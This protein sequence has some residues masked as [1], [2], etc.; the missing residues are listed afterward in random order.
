MKEPYGEGVAS[1]SGPESCGCNRKGTL[2]ALTGVRTG[3]VLSLESFTPRAPTTSYSAEGDTGRT[4]SARYAPGPA[5]SETPGTYGNSLHGIREIPCLAREDGQSEGR[6]GTES[7]WSRVPRDGKSD[8]GDPRGTKRNL[9][10][11]G[12]R[13][14]PKGASQ[15]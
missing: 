2:E 12:P 11:P 13:W 14:E 6:R 4:V 10:D 1:H 9:P 3:W 8:E 5:G 7:P 15:R